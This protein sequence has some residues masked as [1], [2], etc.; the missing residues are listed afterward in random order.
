M[1]AQTPACVQFSS[2][3]VLEAVAF[4]GEGLRG[5]SI[6]RTSK[7]AK[8]TTVHRHLLRPAGRARLPNAE[9]GHYPI[10]YRS[11]GRANP[12]R[13]LAPTL[14]SFAL[15]EGPMRELRD[16]LGHSVVLSARTPRG[17]LVLNTV[18]GTSAIEIGVRHSSG[19][20]GFRF[21]QGEVLLLLSPR[22][23]QERVLS[24][25]LQRF[26]THTLVDPRLVEETS[27]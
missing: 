24:R 14:I 25:P 4:S 9:P 1:I 15:P 8:S 19:F 2:P 5:H 20:L 21:A 10:R 17:P 26:T 13:T 7:V 27:P 6:G 22:P 11:R 3:D 23:Q 12:R 16:R 18:Q